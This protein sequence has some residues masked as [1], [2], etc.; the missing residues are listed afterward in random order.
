MADEQEKVTTTEEQKETVKLHKDSK[1]KTSR[2]PKAKRKRKTTAT[3][4]STKKESVESHKT[5][6]KKDEE[7][8][9]AIPLDKLLA[10]LLIVSVLL[11]AYLFFQI[12]ANPTEAIKPTITQPGNQPTQGGANVA[13]SKKVNLEFYVMSHCPYGTQV[14][15]AIAP[16]LAKVGNYVNFKVDYIASINPDGGFNSLHGQTEVDENI[17]ELCV[18]KYYPENYKYMG[19]IVCRDKTIQSTDWQSCATQSGMDVAKI[20]ACSEGEEG[21]KLHVDSIGRSTKAQASGSPTIFLNSQKYSGGRRDADFLK[22]ICNALSEKP[23]ACSEIPEDAKIDIIVLTDKRCAACDTTPLEERLKGVFTSATIKKYDYSTPEG[24]KLYEETKVGVLPAIL[25]DEKVSSSSGY[26]DVQ[27]YLVPAGKY[28]SLR[29]GASFNPTKEVCDN[30]IDD[31]ANGKIDC[32]DPDC[33][34]TLVC[35]QEIPK[36]LDVFVMSQCPYG[37]QALDAMKEVLANMK[38]ADFSVHYIAGYD[39]AT[40]QFN[41]LHGQGEVDENIR[42]LCAIKYYPENHKYMDYIWCRNKDIRSTT[43]EGCAQEAGM[44]AAKIK[45][46]A[47]GDEGKNL[48]KEDLKIAQEL[49]IGAS[50]TWMANNKYQFSGIAADAIRQSLCRYNQGLAGCENVLSTD[51]GAVPPSGAC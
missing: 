7:Y 39:E 17:R 14:L 13:D 42:E 32:D 44:D 28:Q 18:M 36:K 5:T 45:Q 22:A 24:K 51:T 23:A 43:W 6:K 46:C 34:N 25:F 11:N 37:T 47:E 8:V 20:K 12:D 41:S 31:T 26:S 29:I 10:A 35:R 48:L 1:P 30:K 40:G 2:K 38:D 9:T 21:S 19:Y 16:V 3:S 33:E 4:K 15:D 49:G 27:S 50:P